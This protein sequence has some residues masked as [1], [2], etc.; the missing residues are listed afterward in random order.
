MLEIWCWR[1]TCSI[2]GVVDVEGIERK[3][4]VVLN[5]ISVGKC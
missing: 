2:D 1:R 4:K 5:K 3:G